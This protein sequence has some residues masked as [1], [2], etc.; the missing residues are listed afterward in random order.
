MTALPALFASKTV[1]NT[2]CVVWVGA[3][4]SKGYGCVTV[5]GSSH[6]VHRVAWEA[7]H[8]AIPAGMTIDHLCRV[9]NCV[10]TAHMEVVTINENNL[11][12]HRAVGDTCKRGHELAGPEDIYVRSTGTSECRHCRRENKQRR[13]A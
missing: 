4:N 11:R 9:R 7:E 5:N 6:L 8:G 13:A 3:A 10:N 1:A 12:K 2:G